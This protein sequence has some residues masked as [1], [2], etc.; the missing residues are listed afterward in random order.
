MCCVVIVGEE[1]VG[2]DYY[3]NKRYRIKEF[4]I[5]RL[6]PGSNTP[7]LLCYRVVI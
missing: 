7:S 3:K 5:L 2:V 4:N 6:R 1:G